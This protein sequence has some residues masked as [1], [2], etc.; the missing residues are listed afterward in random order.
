MRLLPAVG[1]INSSVGA[2][3]NCCDFTARSLKKTYPLL[4]ESMR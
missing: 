3:G 4:A 2:D 1:R